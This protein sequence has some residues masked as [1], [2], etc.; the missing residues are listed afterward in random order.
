[1]VEDGRARRLQRLVGKLKPEG[2]IRTVFIIQGWA[3]V[4]S[5]CCAFGHQ[6]HRCFLFSVWEKSARAQHCTATGMGGME[7][8]LM[9]D[10]L[11]ECIILFVLAG[12]GVL[13]LVGGFTAGHTALP[14]LRVFRERTARLVPRCGTPH[15]RHETQASDSMLLLFALFIRKRACE[16]LFVFGSRT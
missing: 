10:C 9:V 8:C 13:I 1:V 6:P 4:R 5:V 16:G 2:P 15:G 7:G 3:L 14:F 11:K 12:E